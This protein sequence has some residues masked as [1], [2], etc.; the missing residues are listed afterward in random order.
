MTKS[1]KANIEC[2]FSPNIPIVTNV[3]M[4]S[5]VTMNEIVDM[6]MNYQREIDYHKE[7]FR[8]MEIET[9]K[10]WQLMGKRIHWLEEHLLESNRINRTNDMAKEEYKNEFA[11]PVVVK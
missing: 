9:L 5:N 8:L 10:T 3:E 4:Y 1:N 11:F 6:A 2:V 7:R